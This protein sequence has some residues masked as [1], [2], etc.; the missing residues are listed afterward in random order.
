MTFDNYG[1]SN[2]TGAPFPAAFNPA[3]VDVGTC[4]DTMLSTIYRRSRGIHGEELR[5][6]VDASRADFEEAADVFA[7][8]VAFC[9]AVALVGHGLRLAYAYSLFHHSAHLFRFHVVKLDDVARH[10]SV[11]N[12]PNAQDGMPDATAPVDP[13]RWIRTR[14]IR[15]AGVVYHRKPYCGNPPAPLSSAS[16]VATDDEDVGNDTANDEEPCAPD[17]AN[18]RALSCISFE[19]LSVARAEQ[20][21]RV[22]QFYLT[23]VPV[24]T[25]FEHFVNGPWCLAVPFWSTHWSRPHRPPLGVRPDPPRD[26]VVAAA[27]AARTT[28][29]VDAALRAAI[30]ALPRYSVTGSWGGYTVSLDASLTLSTLYP[31]SDYTAAAPKPPPTFIVDD[32]DN[33]KRARESCGVVYTLCTAFCLLFAL[34]GIAENP[35]TPFGRQTLAARAAAAIASARVCELWIC[36]EAIAWAI[37]MIAKRGDMQALSMP[38]GPRWIRRIPMVINA[39]VNEI[40]AVAPILAYVARILSIA[41][42]VAMASGASGPEDHTDVYAVC[43]VHGG[44]IALVLQALSGSPEQDARALT[45]PAM[46]FNGI[47]VRITAAIK[48]GRLMPPGA[49]QAISAADMRF[50]ALLLAVMLMAPFVLS[51]I[52]ALF[53]TERFGVCTSPAL[54]HEFTINAVSTSSP[55]YHEYIRCLNDVAARHSWYSVWKWRAAVDESG[56]EFSGKSEHAQADVVAEAIARTRA[57]HAIRG[58]RTDGIWA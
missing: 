38:Y 49:E 53:G 23:R 1:Y 48:K 50:G 41:V 35:F 42:L 21:L 9:L 7:V 29:E 20:E 10:V 31:G 11:S 36:T 47:I 45:A 44:A 2:Y 57:E 18:T 15:C 33:N 19:S 32:A 55:E 46:S 3:T 27:R 37:K 6:F 5:D 17:D 4:I 52:N 28:Q 25:E 12:T 54:A 40:P 58:A 34:G 30:L 26:S 14:G 51:T 39:L 13:F 16:D 24:R 22:A 56:S 8:A 43:S